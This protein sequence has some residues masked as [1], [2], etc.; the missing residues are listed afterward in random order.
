MRRWTLHGRAAWECI[1]G[2]RGGK[3]AAHRAPRVRPAARHLGHV[4]SPAARLR[5]DS[6]RWQDDKCHADPRQPR[7]PGNSSAEPMPLGA[8]AARPVQSGGWGAA[9]SSG[10]S[11]SSVRARRL[12][13]SVRLGGRRPAKVAK[14]ARVG[15]VALAIF[16]CVIGRLATFD[17][18]VAAAGA[19]PE[20]WQFSEGLALFAGRIQAETSGGG[21]GTA[22]IGLN[23]SIAGHHGAR[24]ERRRSIF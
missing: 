23:K 8:G 24:P 4:R 7:G 17:E 9:A 3:V 13:R 11:S 6:R 14:V 1:A 10:S 19:G 18:N 20:I 21:P 16:D 2:T 12:I 15:G 22:E 5:E